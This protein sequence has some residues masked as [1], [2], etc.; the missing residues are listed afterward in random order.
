[1]RT[2]LDLDDEL[3]KQVRQIAARTNRTMTSIVE[4]A[5]RTALN[6]RSEEKRRKV[7]LPVSKRRGGLRPGIDIDNTAALLDILDAQDDAA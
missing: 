4:D 3:L 5:L 2:T 6:R 7:E 1:M